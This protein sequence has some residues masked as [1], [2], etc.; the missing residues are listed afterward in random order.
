MEVKGYEIG[1]ADCS[2]FIL[3]VGKNKKYLKNLYVLN[4]IKW[5]RKRDFI[6]VQPVVHELR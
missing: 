6:G 1:S 4:Y 3:L 2:R 5:G